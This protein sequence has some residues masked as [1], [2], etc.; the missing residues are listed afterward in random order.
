MQK[1][2]TFYD[3]F[4]QAAEQNASLETFKI[5]KK[6]GVIAGRTFRR[7]HELVTELAAG[8]R[9]AGVAQDDRVTLLCDSS[10]NW[11]LAD[12]AII[13]AGA[14][15]VPRGTDVTDDD[16]RYIVGH[17]ESRWAIVQKQKDRD[18]LLKFQ[19]DLPALEKIWVLE[20]DDS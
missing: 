14:V 6:T 10:P 18:R 11:I 4:A 13:A 17:S 19:S 9:S 12:A 5:R 7:I 16:I 2:K 20:D 15:C 3:L 8:L 1:P